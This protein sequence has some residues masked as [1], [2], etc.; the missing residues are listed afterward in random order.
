MNQSVAA[1]Y[2]IG[3]WERIRY[4]VQAHEPPPSSE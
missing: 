4:H 1:K 2:Q 3:E